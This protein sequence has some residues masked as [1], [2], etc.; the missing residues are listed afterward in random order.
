MLLPCVLTGLSPACTVQLIISSTL[1][2]LYLKGSE[3][4]FEEKIYC[5][6]D[7]TPYS[8]VEVYRRFGG[9]HYRNLKG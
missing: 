1:A 6:W 3:S 4:L 5:L 2:I 9:T 8:L 7:M